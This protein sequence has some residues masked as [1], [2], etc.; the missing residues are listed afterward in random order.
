MI[1]GTISLSTTMRKNDIYLI[2]CRVRGFQSI[3]ELHYTYYSEIPFYLPGYL[4]E[5]R[6]DNKWSN[7]YYYYFSQGVLSCD[8]NTI[9]VSLVVYLGKPSY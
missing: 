2:F 1:R 5:R 3:N 4:G 9:M 7:Y 8:N 6:R